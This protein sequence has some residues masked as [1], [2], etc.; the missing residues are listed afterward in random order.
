MCNGI[1]F[2]F[3]TRAYRYKVVW[4]LRI[5]LRISLFLCAG[6]C[7]A[8]GF[9]GCGPSA[10]RQACTAQCGQQNDRCVIDAMTAEALQACSERTSQ[11]LDPCR[12]K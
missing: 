11:C 1:G 7:G 6:L 5:V 3:P 8:A 9:V 12:M 10:E 4:M 2:G